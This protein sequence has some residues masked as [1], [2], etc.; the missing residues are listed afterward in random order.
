MKWVEIDIDPN[1]S[2]EEQEEARAVVERA[3]FGHIARCLKSQTYVSIGK[4][5][6]YSLYSAQ[7]C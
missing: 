2:T 4:G 7:D 3:L 1:L 6:A 5:T